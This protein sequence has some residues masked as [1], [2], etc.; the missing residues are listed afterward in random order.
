MNT[1]FAPVAVESDRVACPAAMRGWRLDARRAMTLRPQLASRLHITQGR[2]WVTLGVPHQGAG[3]ESGDV[4]LAAG[5]SLLVPAGAR[6]VIEPWQPASAGPVRFD[7]CAEPE[8]P[9]LARPDRFGREVVAPSR[10]LAAALGQA[11]WA[12]AR[13]MRG[14]LGYSEYLVAGRG[15]ALTP[16]ESNPP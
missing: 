12:L 4:M 11:G 7:W 9:A 3:N 6:L 10:E 8:T 15:R 13:L 16:F 5:E 2:A 1:R 14:L